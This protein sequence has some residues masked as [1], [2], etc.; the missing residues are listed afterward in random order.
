M[1]TPYVYCCPECGETKRKQ[2]VNTEVT[3][4]CKTCGYYEDAYKGPVS[5][6]PKA[7]GPGLIH[8]IGI[9]N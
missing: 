8:Y 5:M 1:Q 2:I 4:E 7:T 3:F 9:R 6:A